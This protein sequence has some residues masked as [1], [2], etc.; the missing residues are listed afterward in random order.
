MCIIEE[1]NE[2]KPKY[3][4]DMNESSFPAFEKIESPLKD[5]IDEKDQESDGFEDLKIEAQELKKEEI[6]NDPDAP[7]VKLHMGAHSQLIVDDYAS[8][9]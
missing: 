4:L 8:K 2:E 1:I 5:K 3:I 9:K 6:K 7:K